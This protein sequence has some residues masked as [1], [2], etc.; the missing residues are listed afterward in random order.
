MYSLVGHS[1]ENL[2]R[3][4]LAELYARLLRPCSD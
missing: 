1:K 2:Q 3:E 4:L